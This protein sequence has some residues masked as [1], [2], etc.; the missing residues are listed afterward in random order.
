MIYL[1]ASKALKNRF[2]KFELNVKKCQICLN[3]GGKNF[4]I[5]N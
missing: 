1:S 3:R 2:S 5:Q 4:H